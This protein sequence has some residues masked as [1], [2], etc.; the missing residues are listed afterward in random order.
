MPQFANAH[1]SPQFLQ[2][3]T[4]EIQNSDKQRFKFVLLIS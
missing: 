1:E 2:L 3:S 4:A